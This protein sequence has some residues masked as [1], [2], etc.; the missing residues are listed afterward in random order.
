MRALV[1]R[2]YLEYVLSLMEIRMAGVQDEFG[3][4]LIADNTHA[5]AESSSII[6][7]LSNIALGLN[8][9]RTSAG[10]HKEIETE[11]DGQD[12]ALEEI[13]AHFAEMVSGQMTATTFTNVMANILQLPQRKDKTLDSIEYLSTL[14]PVQ[15]LRLGSIASVLLELLHIAKHHVSVVQFITAYDWNR[16]TDIGEAVKAVFIASEAIAETDPRVSITLSSII[17]GSLLSPEHKK[18][19]GKMFALGYNRSRMA[20]SGNGNFRSLDCMLNTYAMTASNAPEYSEIFKHVSFMFTDQ[21][22]LMSSFFRSHSTSALTF[23]EKGANAEIDKV[24][25]L[26]ELMCAVLIGHTRGSTYAFAK[27]EHFKAF[28]QHMNLS[29]DNIQG[30]VSDMEEQA[31]LEFL[32][33]FIRLAPDSIEGTALHPIYRNIGRAGVAVSSY[34]SL[35]YLNFTVNLLHTA[36]DL[37]VN[38]YAKILLLVVPQD[39]TD[40]ESRSNHKKIRIFADFLEYLR[41]LETSDYNKRGIHFAGDATIDL[42]PSDIT[43]GDASIQDTVIDNKGGI[44]R[45]LGD[46]FT[47]SPLFAHYVGLATY[48][49]DFV[50]VQQNSLLTDAN[51]PLSQQYREYRTGLTMRHSQE[52]INRAPVPFSE[53][54]S[55]Y[56]DLDICYLGVGVEEEGRNRGI[57]IAVDSL[58]PIVQKLTMGSNRL[59]SAEDQNIYVFVENTNTDGTTTNYMKDIMKNMRADDAFCVRATQVIETKHI[60]YL[61]INGADR[62]NFDIHTAHHITVDTSALPMEWFL[63]TYPGLAPIAHRLNPVQGYFASDAEVGD[64]IDWILAFCNIPATHD[65]VQ[66]IDI[67]HI[68]QLLTITEDPESG[69]IETELNY[70]IDATINLITMPGLAERR[71]SHTVKRAIYTPQSNLYVRSFTMTQTSDSFVD[72]IRKYIALTGKEPIILQISREPKEKIAVWIGTADA[73][74][75]HSDSAPTPIIADPNKDFDAAEA[76]RKLEEEAAKKKDEED[77]ARLEAEREAEAKAKEEEEKKKNN[78]V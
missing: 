54:T 25:H 7:L 72:E 38:R 28:S 29:A 21:D 16:M 17:E 8:T 41:Q 63:E 49:T 65:T 66:P 51:D 23:E 37:T 2:W 32:R 64:L 55:L 57:M 78:P 18:E 50:Q 71:T 45:N 47:M 61:P 19:I 77:I 68:P 9:L 62:T 39:W 67:V 48:V 15:T 53:V 5:L 56:A 12:V 76:K 10:I 30:L 26:G 31:R 13:S 34:S 4:A 60:S 36:W 1:K 20:I 27:S 3:R 58:A 43:F 42:M 70:T 52:W 14:L 11:Y 40:I 22:K 46:L 44:S 74:Y 6:E 73:N 33:L 69:E 75:W 59:R 24:Y 35:C